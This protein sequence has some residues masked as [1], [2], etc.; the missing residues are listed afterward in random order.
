VKT[1]KFK[2]MLW[3]TTML[4]IS[5]MITGW[6]VYRFQVSGSYKAFDSYLKASANK[7]VR[8]LKSTSFKNISFQSFLNNIGTSNISYYLFDKE[9]NQI[10]SFISEEDSNLQLAQLALEKFLSG[11]SNAFTMEKTRVLSPE[12]IQQ[13]N[14]YRILVVPFQKNKKEYYLVAIRSMEEFNATISNVTI[15]A[16][17]GLTIVF[18]VTMLVGYI[19]ISKALKPIEMMALQMKNISTENLSFRVK[20]PKFGSEIEVLETSINTALSRLEDGV[21]KIERFSSTAAH[22]L[23]TPISVIKSDAQ[24]ALLKK[25]KNELQSA[26]EKII[27]KTDE[28]SRLIDTLLA[29]TRARKD[30]VGKFTSVDLS[31][32]IV[33]VVEEFVKKYPNRI[34]VESQA[35]IITK[36]DRVLLKE[37]IKNIVENA[38]KYTSGKVKLLLNTEHLVISDEGPGMDDKTLENVF[39]E[40]FRGRTDVPGFGLGLNLVKRIAALHNMNVNINSSPKSGTEVII[41]FLKIS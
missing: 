31:E 18:I 37:M 23:R 6:V 20:V 40:F 26:L 33:E 29:L 24:L 22:E 21:K 28:M 15:W 34:E 7:V 9:K 30:I 38:C 12:N 2:I 39:K 41:D 25:S 8:Y 4:V 27:V 16:W 5:F 1:I 35:D 32:I 3:F 10:I 14:P 13:S 17:I 19:I 36:G 11:S